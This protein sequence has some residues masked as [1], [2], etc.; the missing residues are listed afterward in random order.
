MKANAVRSQ[1]VMEPVIKEITEQLNAAGLK[2]VPAPGVMEGDIDA[3]VTIDPSNPDDFVAV[4]LGLTHA[5]SFTRA[6]LGK[7]YKDKFG[8]SPP[9]DV[10]RLLDAIFT[11]HANF[12]NAVPGTKE[13]TNQQYYMTNSTSIKPLRQ[14][15]EAD[16]KTKGV[17][18]V[19]WIGDA[20]GGQF[21]RSASEESLQASGGLDCRENH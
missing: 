18:S 8:G 4:D 19:E 16:L 10:A 3:P 14:A 5:T 20:G 1:K 17:E 2:A 9:R 21:D 13:G 11:R 6:E 7:A 12:M 15:Y